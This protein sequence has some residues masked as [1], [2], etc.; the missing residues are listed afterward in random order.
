MSDFDFKKMVPSLIYEM[1]GS[2]VLMTIFH[3]GGITAYTSALFFTSFVAWE[4]CG[5]AFN[6][7][8]TI[9]QA[10][11]KDKDVPVKRAIEAL[12][13]VI[14]QCIGMFKGMFLSYMMSIYIY[15]FNKQNDQTMTIPTENVMCPLFVETILKDNAID[16]VNILC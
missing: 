14:A 2:C 5:A 10:I 6:P 7:A 15:N 9:G 4:T 3:Q 1:L 13:I 8:L 16:H 11:F 12:I